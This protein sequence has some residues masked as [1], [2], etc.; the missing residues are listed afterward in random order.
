MEPKVAARL[1]LFRAFIGVD[2]SSSSCSV[3]VDPVVGSH[4]LLFLFFLLLLFAGR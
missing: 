4:E 2:S 1:L 3:A